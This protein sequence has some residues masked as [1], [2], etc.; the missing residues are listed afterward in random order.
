MRI[1]LKCSAYKTGLLMHA[2]DF[3]VTEQLRCLKWLATGC[4]LTVLTKK[5]TVCDKRSAGF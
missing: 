4:A 3:G 1:N 2:G 5:A